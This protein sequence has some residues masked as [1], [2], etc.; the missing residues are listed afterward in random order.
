MTR[1]VSPSPE[2]SGELVKRLRKRAQHES[3]ALKMLADAKTARQTDG[4]YYEGITPEQSDFWI[5][6]DALESAQAEIARL[7]AALDAIIDRG[8]ERDVKWAGMS[9]RDIALA[10][11]KGNQP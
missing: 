10:A 5:A 1:T 11:L 2:Q 6:A 3:D 4:G 9:A 8:T 7:T